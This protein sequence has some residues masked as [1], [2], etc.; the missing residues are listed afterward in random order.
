M[1]GDDGKASSL[2]ANRIDL[3]DMTGEGPMG[4]PLLTEVTNIADRVECY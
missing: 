2:S 4:F 3:E 1:L